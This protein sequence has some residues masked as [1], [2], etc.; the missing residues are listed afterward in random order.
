VFE[1]E[2]WEIE[3]GGEV[4]LRPEIFRFAV[5]NSLTLLNLVQKQ[6]NLE[7]IFHQLTRGN[8]A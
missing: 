2:N 6:Q 1:G 5:E 8:D 4:D 3:S 7:S